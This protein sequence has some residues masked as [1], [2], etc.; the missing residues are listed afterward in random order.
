MINKLSGRLSAFVLETDHTSYVF[1]VTASGHLEHLYYG[2]RLPLES[3][4]DCAVFR[5][6]RAF[7][8]GNCIVYDKEHPAVLLED[9]CL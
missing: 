1:A 8:L 6:K 5:E 4:D 2:E 9:M 3:A 7:E